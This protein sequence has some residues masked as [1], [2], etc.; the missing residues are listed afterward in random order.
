MAA[1]RE[2]T[3]RFAGEYARAGRADKGRMLGALVQVTGWTRDHARRAIRSANARKGAAR[4]QR[5]KPRERKHSYD[6]LIVLQEVGSAEGW[7]HD[8]VVPG[9]GSRWKDGGRAEDLFR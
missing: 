8:R 2:I 7:V 3:K 5:R 6:A 1:L 4:D 9:W